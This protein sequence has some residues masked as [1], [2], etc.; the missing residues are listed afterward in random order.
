MSN[1]GN[2]E[3]CLQIA[4][5]IFAPPPARAPLPLRW[6]RGVLPTVQELE[7]EDHESEL[8]PQVDADQ[9]RAF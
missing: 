7:R 6:L 3:E 8:R 4:T 5:L 2:S 9:D 1:R